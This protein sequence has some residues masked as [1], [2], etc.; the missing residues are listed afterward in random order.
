VP[1]EDRAD[2][3]LWSE[4]TM[5]TFGSV[6]APE[7]A[8]DGAVKL[9]GYITDLVAQR[10][11]APT[12]D[13]LGALV[14]ARDEGDALSELELVIFGVNLLVAGHESIAN[15]L[16]NIIVTLLD[17][18]EV[19]A[20]LR[21][22]PELLPVALEELMRFV[23]LPSGAGLTRIATEDVQIGDVVMKKG[24]AVLIVT[25]SANRDESVFDQPEEFDLRRRAARQHLAFGHGP[26]FCPGAQLARMVLQVA[27]GTLLRRL[28]GLRLAEPVE[29]KKGSLLR[30]PRRLVVAW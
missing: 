9:F 29:F 23:P 27:V 1:F 6:H 8:T 16:G 19:L 22:E 24:D 15:E 18:P 14:V 26:H 3:Q 21:E 7:E 5:S 30:G 4:Q 13:L 28:P 25:A 17:R 10:R 2:F 12:D 20:S 11:A